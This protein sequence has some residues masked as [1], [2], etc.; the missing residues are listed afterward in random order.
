MV[1]T[2]RM[3]LCSEF[4]MSQPV[5]INFCTASNG[6]NPH[7]TSVCMMCVSVLFLIFS[8]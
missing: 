6:N 4:L 1:T 8:A 2:L 7:D 5:E 3:S